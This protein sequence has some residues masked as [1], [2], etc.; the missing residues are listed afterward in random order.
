MSVLLPSR[1]SKIGA[2]LIR[3]GSNRSFSRIAL[4]PHACRCNSW[5]SRMSGRHDIDLTPF[6]SDDQVPSD[7]SASSP[8]LDE[9]VAYVR[10]GAICLAG[11]VKIHSRLG[12][13]QIATAP[14]RA[15]GRDRKW[16]RTNHTLYAL[17]RRAGEQPAIP[18]IVR[19]ACCDNW[20]V[21]YRFASL[22]FHRCDA[23]F[24]AE[25]RRRVV[26]IHEEPRVPWPMRR[27]A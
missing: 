5:R 22:A 4:T 20:V 12:S 24:D 7:L 26:R 10:D 25:T 15:I 14:L 13:N 11:R 16:A 27:P 19:M 3:N 18:L 2:A 8:L 1:P 23:E 9:W 17:G 6:E 21:A